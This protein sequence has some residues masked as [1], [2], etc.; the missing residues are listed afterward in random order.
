[1]E[2]VKNFIDKYEI[3]TKQDIVLLYDNVAVHRCGFSGWFMRMLLHI[4]LAIPPYTP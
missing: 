2:A 1:M 4:K 3:N